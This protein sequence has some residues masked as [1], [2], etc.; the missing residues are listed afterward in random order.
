[1]L[2]GDKAQIIAL[3]AV[4][5]ALVMLLFFTL[6]GI[7]LRSCWRRARFCHPR[8]CRI[9]TICSSRFFWRHWFSEFTLAD[10]RCEL[11][12]GTDGWRRR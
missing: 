2:D 1:M 6:C 12:A 9:S 4:V 7:Y 8:R 11:A 5:L 10:R 3:A